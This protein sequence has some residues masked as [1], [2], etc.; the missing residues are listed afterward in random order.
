MNKIVL[1][2]AFIVQLVEACFSADENAGPSYPVIS[3]LLKSLNDL[4]IVLV[5][6]DG[7]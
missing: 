2:I 4:D 3:A 1:G 7:R 6:D 5:S